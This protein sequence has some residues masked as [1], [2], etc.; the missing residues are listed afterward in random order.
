ML[1]FRWHNTL[2]PH[3]RKDEEEGLGQRGKFYFL[4]TFNCCFHLCQI[5][6][7][8]QGDIVLVGLRDFQDDKADIIHKY[9]AVMLSIFYLSFDK[10]HCDCC[11]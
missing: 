9:N 7:I 5:H 8:S 6:V 10:Y 4:V 1:L 11:S 2:G 3:S